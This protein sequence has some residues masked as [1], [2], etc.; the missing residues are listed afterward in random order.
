MELVLLIIGIIVFLMIVGIIG[1]ILG[2]ILWIVDWCL[3]GC[4]TIAG[5]FLWIIAILITIAIVA[6]N[7]INFGNNKE[8]FIKDFKERVVN[9]ASWRY[10]KDYRQSDEFLDKSLDEKFEQAL[11]SSSGKQEVLE[12]IELYYDEIHEY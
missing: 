4:G 1:K 6:Q 10:P 3:G 5:C 2:F 9:W 7:M 11:E 12:V 8:E